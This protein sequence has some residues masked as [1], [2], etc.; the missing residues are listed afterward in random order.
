MP[1]PLELGD[2]ELGQVA[3]PL[4]GGDARPR[5][6]SGPGRSRTAAWPPWRW[7][8]GWRPRRPRVAHGVATHEEHGRLARAQG[9]GRAGHDVVD[10]GGE[11]A[12]RDGSWR[13]PRPP[14][15]TRRRAPPA[16][17]PRRGDRTQPGRPSTASARQPVGRA[18]RTGTS[19][20]P[21]GPGS[22]CPRPGEG[23]RPRWVV[24]W[25]PTTFTIGVRAR[26]ALWRLAMPLPSPGPRCSRV[27]A[28]RPRH[29][30]VA[31]GGAG[32]HPLEEPEHGPHLRARRRARPRNAS[33]RC[34]GWRSRRRR[35]C[36]RG[37]G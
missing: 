33:P 9:L 20:T 35:R 26:R 25:S 3:E 8:P 30:A 31:V 16:W 11:D 7:P 34:R 24:A 21:G 28:G 32:D 6:R 27:A 4:H 23:R 19:A 29:A 10:H 17:P 2:G 37:S 13:A 18:P 15:T 36:R 22:R 1:G 14:A 12:H 5:A